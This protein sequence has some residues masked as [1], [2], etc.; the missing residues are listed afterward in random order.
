MHCFCRRRVVTAGLHVVGLRLC[1]LQKTRTATLQPLC[2]RSGAQIEL[3]PRIQSH[4]GRKV[5]RARMSR[6]VIAVLRK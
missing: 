3:K 1:A 6:Y 2:S 4:T 5:S